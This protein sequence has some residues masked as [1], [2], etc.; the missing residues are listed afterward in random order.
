MDEPLSE[1]SPLLVSYIFKVESGEV[2]VG[3]LLETSEKQPNLLLTDVGE[4][5]S[6]DDVMFKP[7]EAIEYEKFNTRSPILKETDWIFRFRNQSFRTVEGTVKLIC[8]IF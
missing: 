6:F 7:S 3:I 4:D 8:L 2:K 1:E 5:Y